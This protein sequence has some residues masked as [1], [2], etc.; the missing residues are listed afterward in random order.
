[1]GFNVKSLLAL[2]VAL[3]QCT[4]ECR[5]TGFLHGRMWLGRFQQRVENIDEETLVARR[6]MPRTHSVS[7][8]SFRRAVGDSKDNC[9]AG[10]VTDAFGAFGED[11]KVPLASSFIGDWETGYILCFETQQLVPSSFP[12]ASPIVTQTRL[13]GQGL[14]Y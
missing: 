13:G 5:L 14:S 10:A 12:S 7:S 2:P 1:M 8:R 11:A 4:V 3:R 9:V 6:I